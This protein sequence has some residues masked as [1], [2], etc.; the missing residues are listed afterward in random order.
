MKKHSKSVKKRLSIDAKTGR[1]IPE[2]ITSARDEFEFIVIGTGA[3]GGPVAANLAKAG[4][5]VLVL[6]AGGDAKNPSSQFRYEVPGSNPRSDYELGWAY[7]VNS[8]AKQKDREK[9]NFYVP[10]KGL[11][12]PRG[13]SIGGSTNVNAMIAL[14]PDNSDWDNI[15]KLTGDSSWNSTDMRQYYQ[16]LERADYV[17][18]AKRKRE[19]RGADGW[20]SLESVGVQSNLGKDPWLAN[21]IATRVQHEEGGQAF[22]SAVRTGGEFRRDP[23]DWS[24]VKKRGTGLADPPRAAE[25]GARRGTRELLLNT[26]AQLPERLTIRTDCLV[27]RLIFDDVHHNRV[28]GVEY[29]EG[30]HLY[31]ASLLAEQFSSRIGTKRQVFAT[32]E[33]ILAAGAFNS[34]QVLMLS[35]IGPKAELRKHGIKVRVDLPGVGRNLQDRLETGIVCRL[36]FEPDIYK[37]CTWGAPGDPCLAEFYKNPIG[38]AYRTR[39][40][41]QMYMIKRSHPNRAIPNLVIFGFTGTFRG[42]YHPSMSVPTDKNTFTWFTLSGHTQNTGGMVTLKSADPRATP[43]INFNNFEDGTDTA[44][45]DLEALLQGVKMARKMA[46]S[47]ADGP[48][49]G[50]ISPGQACMT[51]DDV[52]RFIRNETWGHHASCSNKM[53]AANDPMAVVNSRF[54]VHKVERLRIVDASVFPRIP[55]LFI[56]VPIYMIAEKAS[57]LIL[58]DNP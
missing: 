23:N 36:P 10:G 34:P 55:G 58:E 52:K 57:D 12:Y 26:A 46:A 21:Y 33:V 28:I 39:L 51:D 37:G 38:G 17:D 3:G 27:T 31:G 56:V 50:E 49:E 15:A 54:Q 40:S 20:L 6:E 29:L 47:G 8:R 18:P 53:G 24:F 7:W 4:R 11:Y 9:Q 44:G 13:T 1:D 16:R 43:E 25:H 41:R 42:Y 45:E 19:R 30:A 32:R 35:G 5:K 14:S 2:V 48:A 22:L